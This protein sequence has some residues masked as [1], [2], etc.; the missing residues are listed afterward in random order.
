[1]SPSADSQARHGRQ[2]IHVA[3]LSLFFHCRRCGF[4]LPERLV[5]IGARGLS[6]VR[7]GGSLEQM[8][9]YRGTRFLTVEG[10]ADGL[11]VQNFRMPVLGYALGPKHARGF[12]VFHLSALPTYDAA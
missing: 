1:V 2:E 8:D 11:H 10:S 5:F 6:F 12:Q 9:V 7:A 4:V 3:G